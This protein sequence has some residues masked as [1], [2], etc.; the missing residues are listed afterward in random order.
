MNMNDDNSKMKETVKDA[1]EAAL[2]ATL[3]QG[4]TWELIAQSVADFAVG[5]DITPVLSEPLTPE[6]MWTH[7]GGLDGNYGIEV[8][9]FYGVEAYNIV[10]ENDDAEF[11]ADR[12]SIYNPDE[13][14]KDYSEEEDA[15]LLS[16]V[17]REWFRIHIFGKSRGPGSDTSV[18]DKAVA[19]VEASLGPCLKYGILHECIEVQDGKRDKPMFIEF[20]ANMT[21]QRQP[22]NNGGGRPEF[23]YVHLW[24]HEELRFRMQAMTYSD[25]QFLGVHMPGYG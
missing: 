7:M 18:V 13:E 15:K 12:R 8:D 6:Y 10:F 22:Y 19:N 4:G 25:M 20:Y 9:Y 23:P 3:P 14:K 24:E 11:V 2:S 16:E 21:N 1:C 17:L 5:C